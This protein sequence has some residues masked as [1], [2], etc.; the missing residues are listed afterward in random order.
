MRHLAIGYL[1]DW[2]WWTYL[3]VTDERGCR[4]RRYPRLRAY[5]AHRREIRKALWS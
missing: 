3:W 2:A 1:P 4:S 5:L